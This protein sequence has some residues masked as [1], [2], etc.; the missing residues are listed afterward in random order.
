MSVYGADVGQLRDL[1]VAFDGAAGRLDAGRLS[2]GSR[3]QMR[4]WVGPVAARFRLS[5]D[6]QY[7]R[8]VHQMAE[9]LRRA[10][11]ELRD[12]ADQQERASAASGVASAAGG[13][14]SPVIPPFGTPSSDVRAWW[15]TLTDEERK[16]LIA[17]D[18]VRIGNLNGVPLEDRA[19]ANQ[20]TAE[21]R[22][23][24]I[25]RRLDE[26]GSEPPQPN[27]LGAL[28]PIILNQQL[29]ARERW[30][31]ERKELLAE[32]S[33]L[34]AVTDGKRTLVVYDPHSDRIVEM[35]GTPGPNTTKVI[36]YLP[37]TDADMNGFSTGS[38]QQVATYLAQSDRSGG[39][40]AF[41]YKDGPWSKWPWESPAQANTNMD[42]ALS[43]GRQLADF[44]DALKLEP[45]LAGATT[46]GMAHSAGMSILSA[47]EIGGAHYDNEISLGGAMLAPGWQ[48]DPQTDYY[49][50]QYGFDAINYANGVGDLPIESDAFEQRIFNPE[51]HS[52]LGIDYQNEF[53]NHTR[54]AQG[55]A[56]N[57]DALVS[58]YHDIHAD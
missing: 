18:P 51:A 35:I 36:T 44:Q 7:S 27:L 30:L 24:E 42:F 12:N 53:E 39:T 6:S 33:Y 2:I 34:E 54:I 17:E 23:D 40:V 16:R 21:S 1:A 9:D 37:G 29:E 58:I 28:S 15:E 11:R 43:E 3:I 47:S 19:A 46:T 56:T 25:G 31:N 22:I 57:Q 45:E 26:M 32:R 49:H 48:Q 38:T 52:F 41:V 10:A 13:N 20:I 50:Y 14:G 5:W 8:M 4:L 55:P